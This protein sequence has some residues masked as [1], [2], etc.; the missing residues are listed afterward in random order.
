MTEK[1]KVIMF[2][3]EKAAQYR[4]DISGWVSGNGRLWCDERAA[5]YDGCT[6]RPCEDCGEP[7]EKSWLVCKKCRQV[8]DEKR[9]QALPK[10][11]W[12]G[13]GMIYSSTA[14]KYFSTLDEVEEYCEEE[15]VKKD[16]LMLIICEPNYLPLIPDDYGCDELVEDGEL[17]D[18][19]I[20][21]VEDFNKAIK[22]VGPVSWIPGKKAIIL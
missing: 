3:S 21:A 6:H 18:D 17:P 19:A 16:A 2:D 12:D 7:T 9:Y 22:A 14:D 5:R 15:E 13:V 10:E 4:T 11:I 8:R 1:D 20:Q